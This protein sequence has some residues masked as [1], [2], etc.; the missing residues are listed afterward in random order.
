VTDETQLAD[1]SR[2][3]SERLLAVVDRAKAGDHSAIV[4]LRRLMDDGPALASICRGDAA[5]LVEEWMVGTLCFNDPVRREATLHR[6][7]QMRREL[8]GSDPTALERLL[9][10]RT[11]ACW[12]RVQI[13]EHVAGTHGC[14]PQ[15]EFFQRQL[16]RANR[17]FQSSVK[18]LATVRRLAMPV[19]VGVNVTAGSVRAHGEPGLPLKIRRSAGTR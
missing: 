8:E 16:E 19:L 3:A 7:K 18:T 12:L 1:K 14:D 6:L 2:E 11:L 5:E 10:Q 13:A 4:E 9:V 17:L 15:T